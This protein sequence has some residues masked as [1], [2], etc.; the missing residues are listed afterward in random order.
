MERTYRRIKINPLFFV[1]A[2]LL[3]IALA[4]GIY[5]LVGSGRNKEPSRGT[6]VMAGHSEVR[7]L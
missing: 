1:V 5:I 4:V 2:L 3:V 7:A 6:Y